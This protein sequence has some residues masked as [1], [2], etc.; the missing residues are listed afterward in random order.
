MTEKSKWNIEIREKGLYQCL[1]EGG[2]PSTWWFRQSIFSS[3]KLDRTDLY[4]R[5]QII[6]PGTKYRGTAP[7]IWKA[8]QA[9]LGMWIRLEIVDP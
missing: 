7:C 9:K 2:K 6:H 1:N 5:R 3:R 8:E 4:I